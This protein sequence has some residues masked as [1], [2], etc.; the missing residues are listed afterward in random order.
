VPPEESVYI[1]DRP[2]FA[3]VA[4]TLGIRGIRHTSFAA[5]RDALA[6]LGLSLEESARPV[7]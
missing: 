5:T 7:S 4:E 1:D 6:R 2:M 3:D